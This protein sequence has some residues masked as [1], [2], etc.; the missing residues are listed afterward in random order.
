MSPEHIVA[1]GGIIAVILGAVTAW[2]GKKV[3]ELQGR[4]GALEEELKQWKELGI[5]A[6]KYIR[7]FWVWSDRRD[8]AHERGEPVPPQPELPTSLKDQL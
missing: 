2:Q 8:I 4:V 7:R 3:S 1:Y 5:D 6:M